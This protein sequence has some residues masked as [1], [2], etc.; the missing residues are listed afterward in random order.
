MKI[1][2]SY[3]YIVMSEL[4]KLSKPKDN[5]PFGPLA[6]DTDTSSTDPD[7]PPL[8]ENYA[9]K[10]DNAGE[11]QEASPK[12]KKTAQ[13]IIDEIKKEA[14]DLYGIDLILSK[15]DLESS[16][17]LPESILDYF[18]KGLFLDKNSEY[19]IPKEDGEDGE[20]GE[21]DDFKYLLTKLSTSRFVLEQ[22]VKIYKLSIQQVIIILNSDIEQEFLP[23]FL[24]TFSLLSYKIMNISKYLKLLAGLDNFLKTIGEKV[25]EHTESELDA[26]TMEQIMDEEEKTQLKDLFKELILSINQDSS[27]ESTVQP[28]SKNAFILL[29]NEIDNEKEDNLFDLEEK[30]GV[31]GRN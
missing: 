8:L 17:P 18:K 4:S 5:N 26:L 23:D 11:D 27:V 9:K 16:I 30:K 15:D 13:E 3:I 22:Q 31:K 19:Y 29:E 28:L 12:V 21:D 24:D 25:K 2:S 1:K 20:D 14:K 7:M 10:D 6:E